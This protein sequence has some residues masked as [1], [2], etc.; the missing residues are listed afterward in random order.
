MNSLKKL[1][2]NRTTLLLA[3]LVLAGFLSF[4]VIYM[5]SAR[6]STNKIQRIS[7]C[8]DTCVDLYQDKASPDTVAVTVGSYVQFNSKDGKTHD[9]SLG[10]GGSEHVHTGK[11]QS[12]DFGANEGWRV[13]FNEEGSFVFHDHLNPKISVLVV[14]YTA[15]KDYKIQ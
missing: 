9:L 5:V 7:N 2:K 13:Q 10:A 14:V 6:R 11:F 12:G 3:V 15:G 8:K 4:S 1:A